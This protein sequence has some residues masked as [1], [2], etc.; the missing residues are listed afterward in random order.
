MQPLNYVWIPYRDVGNDREQDS[1]ILRAISR[2]KTTY[3]SF[4]DEE[5]VQKIGNQC[6][7]FAILMP[8]VHNCMQNG[9]K[10]GLPLGILK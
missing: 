4:L 5:T 3:E 10:A 6:L 8:S 9:R 2:N 7:N 1:A